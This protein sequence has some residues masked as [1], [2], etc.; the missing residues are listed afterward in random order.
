M[1]FFEILILSF[2][3]AMDCFA[4]SLSIAASSQNN[5]K[6]L[7]WIVAA[8]F[9][10]FHVMMPAIGCYLGSCIYDFIAQVGYWITAGI[11]FFV[12]AKMLKEGFFYKNET[13]NKKLGFWLVVTLA[14]ATSMD[15]VAVGFSF[16][17]LQLD[18]LIPIITIGSVTMLMSL[19]AFQVGKWLSKCLN[20]KW[21]ILLGGLVL[22]LIGLQ[23]IIEDIIL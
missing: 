14:F 11:L 1:P 21:M 20:P 3:L 17:C 8:V 9:G 23:I 16:S 2:A 18:V 5:N 4:V 19:L 7:P 13:I 12:G 10:F 22:I 6:K 15:A